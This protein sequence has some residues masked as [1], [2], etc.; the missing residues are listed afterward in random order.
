MKQNPHRKT[1]LIV[2][3]LLLLAIVSLFLRCKPP[4][5]GWYHCEGPWDTTSIGYMLFTSN[6]VWGISIDPGV[7]INGAEVGAYSVD[8]DGRTVMLKRYQ[9]RGTT[10][11]S[12]SWL[13][14]MNV[15]NNCERCWRTV[16]PI[17]A[18]AQLKYWKT[19]GVQILSAK[20]H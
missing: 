12:T 11:F 15:D 3:A 9:G 20:L 5:E 13:W 14:I 4:V 1:L 2:I 10:M 17:P 8:E 18:D 19:N 6:C 7:D 16:N